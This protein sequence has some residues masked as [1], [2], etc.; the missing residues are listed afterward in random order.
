M[1]AVPSSAAIFSVV[2]LVHF[3]P[4]TGSPA[5]SCSIRRPIASITS[6]TLFLPTAAPRPGGAPAPG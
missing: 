1:P 4:L 2:R 5:V 6:G 3:T